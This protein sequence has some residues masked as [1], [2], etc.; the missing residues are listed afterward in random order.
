MIYINKDT[1][2][3]FALTLTESTTITDPFFLF[4]FVW[5]YDESIAPIYWVGTDYS[6]Y[7]DRYNLFYIEEGVD[8]TFS[9]GQYRYEV[10]ESDQ[11]ITIDENTSETGLTKIE[12]GRMVVYGDGTTI[13]D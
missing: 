13:Y 9:Q 11:S 3:E 6:S 5:E 7:P 2:N 12:E 1:N 8:A 10:Y 4:K